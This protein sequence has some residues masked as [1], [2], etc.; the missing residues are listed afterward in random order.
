MPWK[1]SENGKRYALY[2]ELTL[3]ANKYLN[4][5]NEWVYPKDG[6]A[7]T[8]KPPPNEGSDKVS[9]MATNDKFP[10]ISLIASSFNIL[11]DPVTPA[12]Q[13]PLQF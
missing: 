9:I 10:R 13:L 2:N 7:K 1:D 12:A 11:N 8:D 6:K 3:P 4:S 5:N